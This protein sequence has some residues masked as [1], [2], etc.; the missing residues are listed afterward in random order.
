MS[1]STPSPQASDSSDEPEV[2]LDDNLIPTEHERGGGTSK[3]YAAV[4]IVLSA[5][6]LFASVML[7]IE[8]YKKAANVFYDPNCNIN[9]LIGCGNSLLS[10]QAHILGIPNALIGTLAFGALIAIGLLLY[11]GKK[12]PAVLWWLMAAGGVA[13]IAFVA[14]FVGAS[15]V[16]FHSLCPYCM[17]VWTVA[18]PVGVM[19]I[20]QA[21]KRG[22]VAGE[23]VSAVRRV[24]VRERWL[25]V[26]ALYAIVIFAV[27]VGLRETIALVI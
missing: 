6:G 27:V 14:F 9:P 5:I 16:T 4:L 24:L 1:A 8:T 19:L 13:A 20:S 17:V 7:L 15:I 18:L 25:I 26:I 11:V 10:W 3:G 23:D 21:L 2:V 12:M 22:L